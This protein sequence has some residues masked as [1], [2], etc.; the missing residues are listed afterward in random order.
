MELQIRPPRRLSELIDLAVRDASLLDRTRY[1]PT[2]MTWHRP[3]YPGRKNRSKRAKC[4]VCVAG[5]V[6][7]R[8]LRCAS[9][10][11][12]DV[13]TQDSADP[14]SVTITDKAWR[15]ALWA[16]DEARKGHWRTACRHLYGHQ[17]ERKLDD[18]VREI[19]AP[20]TTEFNDWRELDAHLAS[21]EERATRLRNL[22]L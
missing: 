13:A 20:V 14:R 19:P 5:A 8:T 17:L 9:D 12:I 3:E 2:W 4:M 1:V 7:A 10:T 6:I 11:I 18:A 15:E 16:L 21:L 22:G